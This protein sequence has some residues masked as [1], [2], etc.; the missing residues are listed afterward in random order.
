MNT[1]NK[2]I[3]KKQLKKAIKLINNLPSPN[4]QVFYLPEIYVK[5]FLSNKKK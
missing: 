1:K 4:D 3:T 5:L 2:K